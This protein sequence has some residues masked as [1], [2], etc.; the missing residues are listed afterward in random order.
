MIYG[1]RNPKS[2][3]GH[4]VVSSAERV[5]LFNAFVGGLD[6]HVAVSHTKGDLNERRRTAF[7]QWFKDSGLI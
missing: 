7:A 6:A 5:H 2:R 3:K 4:H 1:N